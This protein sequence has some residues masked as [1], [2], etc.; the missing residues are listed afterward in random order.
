[1]APKFICPQSR[2]CKTPLPLPEKR[3]F[4]DILPEKTA[5]DFYQ[6][7]DPWVGLGTALIL[8]LFVLIITIKS[9]IRYLWHQWLLFRYKRQLIAEKMAE[10]ERLR[11][12]VIESIL[13]KENIAIKQES[14][15]KVA[16]LNQSLIPSKSI[17]KSPYI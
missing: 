1:M 8:F 12:N 13:D 9:I 5:A 10:K 17:E 4:M 6:N 14:L 11:E 2:G 15:S 7:Y 16:F 3:D